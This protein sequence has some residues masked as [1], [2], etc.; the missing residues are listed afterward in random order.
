MLKKSLFDCVKKTVS[1]VI[2]RISNS[3]EGKDAGYVLL[4]E[5]D[6]TVYFIQ[7]GNASLLKYQTIGLSKEGDSVNF[8]IGTTNNIFL[9]EFNNN[10]LSDIVKKLPKKT[11]LLK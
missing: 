9:S 7:R 6:K 3:G 2:S 8:E 1:G 10:T 5:S 4:L 11:P